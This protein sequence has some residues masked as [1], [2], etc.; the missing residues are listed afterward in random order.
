MLNLGN[1]SKTN[2]KGLK[3]QSMQKFKFLILFLLPFMAFAQEKSSGFYGTFDTGVEYLNLQTS[4]KKSKVNKG[5]I[6][7]LRVKAGY[8]WDTGWRF[9]VLFERSGDGATSSDFTG[10]PFVRGT[11]HLPYS[12]S[13]GVFANSFLLGL[14]GGYHFVRSYERDLYVNFYVNS[15]DN[16]Q[17]LIFP[18][19]NHDGY[20]E[21]KLELEGRQLVLPKWSLGYTIGASLANGKQIIETVDD[22]KFLRFGAAGDDEIK[23]DI[24]GMIWGLYGDL[25]W[26]YH[27][28]S[29]MDFFVKWDIKAKF[30]PQSKAVRTSAFDILNNRSLGDVTLHT[31]KYRTFRSGISLGFAF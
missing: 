24:D 4:D 28:N 16:A 18:I 13:D 31:P 6:G 21:F 22:K 26:I 19:V 1:G 9:G 15:V 23:V 11:E 25:K 27:A 14:Q 3:G 8:E 7:T 17:T 2:L 20:T 29:T 30:Y 12:R 5:N 10:A